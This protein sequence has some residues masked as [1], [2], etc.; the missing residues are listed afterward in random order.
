MNLYNP[1]Q[2]QTNTLQNLQ[3][4]FQGQTPLSMVSVSGIEGARAFQTQPNSVV[5][6]FDNSKDL[7]YVKQTDGANYPTIKTF[8]LI[9][10]D[11]EKEKESVFVS[12]EEF[13]Q[14]KQEIKT[15]I[16][17]K[18]SSKGKDEDK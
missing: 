1:N 4:M 12:R 3:T 14:F 15:A 5:P 16:K 17:G 13:E 10:Y 9:P 2:L 6:L 18:G 7:L 11:E 8:K